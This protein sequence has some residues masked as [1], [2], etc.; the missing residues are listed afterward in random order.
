[1][2]TI[3]N[4]FGGRQP[5]IAE[6]TAGAGSRLP[7][8]ATDG[9]SSIYS[10]SVR[11]LASPTPAHRLAPGAYGR[12]QPPAELVAFGN[13]RIPVTELTSIGVDGHQL[14]APAAEAFTLLRSAASADGVS[15]GVISSYRDFATQ[16]R[17][18]SEKGLYSQG[19]LAAAPGTSNHGW[20]LSL[21]LDLDASG[22]AWM[23]DNAWRFGFVEDVPREPW[24]W[25][26]RPAAESGGRR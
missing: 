5:R 22:Q 18:A 25:T 13:G 26:Y 17:L 14:H 24:H 19:G 9:F 21:D 15:L 23:R 10:T 3:E 8:Q 1:M 16:Q 11:S 7:P 12:L 20:G 6:G 2:A 4:R